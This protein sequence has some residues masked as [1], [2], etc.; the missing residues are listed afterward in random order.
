MGFRAE[1]LICTFVNN[2]KFCAKVLVHVNR[3]FSQ[4]EVK[5]SRSGIMIKVYT[6][7]TDSIDSCV[8]MHGVDDNDN[9]RGIKQI[10]YNTDNEY[11][12]SIYKSLITPDFIVYDTH[13]KSL[14][15]VVISSDSYG[16]P[17]S[18]NIGLSGD[19]GYRF[20]NLEYNTK[21]W[22]AGTIN[23]Y[24]AENLSGS[25]VFSKDMNVH[26]FS[27]VFTKT[28]L[29]KMAMQLPHIFEPIL[30]KYEKGKAFKLY[31]NPIVYSDAMR[32]LI[33]QIRQINLEDNLSSILLES[34]VLELL[35]HT[36]REER[37]ICQEFP[38]CVSD[39]EKILE[40]RQILLDNI[41]TP[42]SLFELALRVGTNECK[43]KQG[44]KQLFNNTVFGVLSEYR[45]NKANKYLRD[46]NSSIAEIAEKIGFEHQS[47]FCKAYKR[48]MGISPM[49]FRMNERNVR[50]LGEAL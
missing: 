46:T 24:S 37:Q 29:Q 7:S 44:F 21:T 9:F 33:Y 50:N 22:K 12:K 16:I 35:Y 2:H 23:V 43:I 31:E 25:S 19:F 49:Q 28:F 5:F 30:D 14:D 36:L 15:D 47:S 13:V 18:I 17:L 4:N 20:H 26:S 10:S 11:S 8:Y 32:S 34:K 40:A 41:K 39:K 42:P 38:I 45:I 1:A 3:D 6:S 27:V 48:H